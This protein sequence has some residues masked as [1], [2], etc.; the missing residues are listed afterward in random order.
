[1]HYVFRR[2]VLIIIGLLVMVIYLMLN[3][4]WIISD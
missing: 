3:L 4:L 2:V 1:M